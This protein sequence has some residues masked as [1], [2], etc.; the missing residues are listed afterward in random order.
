MN[1]L[2]HGESL[3]GSD[4]LSTSIHQFLIINYLMCAILILCSGEDSKLS[5]DISIPK[6]RQQSDSFHYSNQIM[7]D[8]G[9]SS[10]SCHYTTPAN[11]ISGPSTIKRTTYT[12]RHFHSSS[13]RV[14]GTNSWGLS[15]NERLQGVRSAGNQTGFV[16]F[17]LLDEDDEVVIGQRHSVVFLFS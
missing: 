3:E 11:M 8:I 16:S 5:F 2:I 13:G 9:D 15:L 1:F 4:I 6:Q 7:Q 12:T 17:S 14:T 10:P